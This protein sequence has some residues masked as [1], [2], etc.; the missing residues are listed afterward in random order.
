MV[1]IEKKLEIIFYQ[2]KHKL[3]DTKYLMVGLLKQSILLTEYLY[4]N[5]KITLKS[6]YKESLQID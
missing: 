3:R 2:N 6:L 5:N 4:S 1:A